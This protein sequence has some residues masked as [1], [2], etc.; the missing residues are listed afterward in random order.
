[1]A[2][3]MFLAW[4]TAL[5]L[6]LFSFVQFGWDKRSAE[7]GL[8]RPPEDSLLLTAILGGWIGA[9]IGRAHFRHKT[10]KQ[11]FGIRLF[12]ASVLNVMGVSALI[13]CLAT[14]A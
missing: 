3:L 5:G 12:G 7:L 8:R 11:P 4:I 2:Q 13:A 14:A 9:Y 6:N 1:M 10:R